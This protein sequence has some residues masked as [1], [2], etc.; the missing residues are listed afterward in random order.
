MK[1]KTASRRERSAYFDPAHPRHADTKRMRGQ[2]AE[3]LRTERSKTFALGRGMYQTVVYPERV[4]YRNRQG[5]W[6]EIDNRLRRV[7]RNGAADGG[8]A[9]ETTNGPLRMRLGERADANPL[10]TLQ[11]EQGYSIRWRLEGAGGAPVAQ[12]NVWTESADEDENRAHEDHSIATVRYAEALPHTDLICEMR[13]DGLKEALVLKNQSAPNRYAWTLDIGGLLWA[14]TGNGGLRLWDKEKPEVDAFLLPAPFMLDATGAEGILHTNWE[15]RDGGLVMTLTPDA[16]FL[17]NAQ[18][19]V[20]IDPTVQSGQVVAQIQDTFISETKGDTN[21][22]TSTTLRVGKH[23]GYGECKA[24]I[25]ILDLPALSS[26]YTI[27]KAWM[28]VAVLT[29]KT[30]TE[31]AYL[32]AREIKEAW[33][34]KT[35]KWNAGKPQWDEAKYL[36]YALVK[37]GEAAATT[38]Q[39]DLTNLVRKWYADKNTNWGVLLETDG[40]QPITL[41][42]AENTSYTSTA[43]PVIYVNY[44]SNAGLESY[45]SYESFGAGRAGTAHVALHSGNLVLTRGLTSMNGNRMPISL[46]MTWNAC[47]MDKNAFG[48]GNG[49]RLNWNQNLRREKPK[50]GDTYYVWTDEDGTEHEFHKH[51]KTEAEKQDTTFVDYYEDRSGLSLK[52]YEVGTEAEIVSKD[53][54][55]LVFDKPTVDYTATNNAIKMIK[56]ALD[57]L[58]NT[59]TFTYVASGTIFQLTQVADGAGRITT[60]A[61]SPTEVT[62]AP[63]GY[64][65][66]VKLT[67]NADKQLI[68]VTDLDSLTSAY[69]YVGGTDATVK[70][71]LKLVKNLV[72]GYHLEPTCDAT[73]RVTEM[74]AYAMDELNVR[75]DG[76]AR[77]Y[78]YFD[79][80]TQVKDLTVPDGKMLTYQFNDYGNVVAV[81][82]EL[83]FASFAKFGMGKPNT[84]EAVSKLQRLV[85]NLLDA[86]DFGVD[87]GWK[88]GVIGA[89]GVERQHEEIRAMGLKP[90]CMDRPGE[91]ETS[92]AEYQ[93]PCE[94][95]EYTFSVYVRSRGDVLA[96]AEAAWQDGEGQWHAVTSERVRRVGSALRLTCTLAL[97]EAAVVRCRVLAGEATGAA[98]FDRA[99]LETGTLCNRHN[100]LRNANFT[101]Q[102]ITELPTLELPESWLGAE[103]EGDPPKVQLPA[104]WLPS[105]TLPTGWLIGEDS[106]VLMESDIKPI[107][108]DNNEYDYP[109]S[110][111]LVAT[112][113]ADTRKA[114]VNTTYKQKFEKELQEQ[115]KTT[116]RKPKLR[117]V[118]AEASENKPRDL[119]ENCLQ[120]QG[121]PGVKVGIYQELDLHGDEGD[122][123]VVGGWCRA[124][125]A[126]GNENR[127]FRLRVRFQKVSGAWADGGTADWN[128]EWV[129]WQYACGAAVAPAAYRKVRVY[130]D[131]DE[132]LNEAQVG[133][134]SLVKEYYGQNFAYDDKNNVTAVSTLLGQ[135]SKAE[136]DKFD[137]L[138]S[139]VQ[140]GRDKSDK[141]T[142]YYGDTDVEKKKHLPLRSETSLGVITETRY[143]M[144]G[145]PVRSVTSNRADGKV[146]KA[147]TGYTQDGNYMIG[148]ID[149]L[150]LTTRSQV[151]PNR[152]LVLST[153]GTNGAIVNYQYDEANRLRKVKTVATGNLYC[154]EYSFDKDRIASISHNTTSDEPDVTYTFE[155]DALGNQTKVK[156]GT[157]TLSENCF[158]KTGDR[159]PELV[160]YTNGGK[161]H[162][163]YDG[164]K[165][166]SGIR[167]DDAI[168]PRFTYAYGANG[169][170]GRV[171]DTEL[172]REAR[173]AYDLAERPV[174]AELYE[175]GALKYR[176]TQEYDRYEQPSLLHERVEE[177]DDTR[178][179]YTITAQY[180]KES[181]PTV[182]TYEAKRMSAEGQPDQESTR[183]LTYSYDGLG[184]LMKRSFHGDVDSETPLFQSEYAYVTGGYGADSTTALVQAIEQAEGKHAYWYDALG[185]IVKERWQGTAAEGGALSF[186]EQAI[187]SVDDETLTLDSA[188]LGARYD[189]TYAYDPLGQLTRVNDQREQATW[190]Y[191]YDQGGNILEKKRYEYTT[192]ADLAALTPEQAIPYAYTD[193]NWKDKLTAYDDKP[194][195]Y[196][197]IGNP[198]TYD[199]WTYTWK[200]GR[201]LHSMEKGNVNAQFTYDHTGLRVKKS[202]SG[203]DTLYT[204]NGKKI[205]HI[206]KGQ[207]GATG[208]DAVQM[209]FFYDA[210]GRPT[211]VRYNG[212]DYAYLHN[213]QGDV[214]GIVDMSGALVVQYGYDAWGKPIGTGGSMAGTLG[215]DNPFRYRGYVW[216]EETGLYYLRSRYY[217]PVWGRFLN[218]DDILGRVAKMLSH[219]AY[220]Y[221]L[222]K[223]VS[224]VDSDGRESQQV[225]QQPNFKQLYIIDSYTVTKDDF[226]TYQDFLN[227]YRRDANNPSLQLPRLENPPTIEMVFG[228]KSITYTTEKVYIP[229]AGELVRDINQL[230]G[231]T[232]ETIAPAAAIAISWGAAYLGASLDPNAVA[233]VINIG[234]SIATTA[235]DKLM[236]AAEGHYH[237]RNTLTIERDSARKRKDQYSYDKC[238]TNAHPIKLLIGVI[239]GWLANFVK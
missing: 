143:D 208:T 206:R 8:Q 80:V 157:Q 144:F 140:P 201:M 138:T 67:L 82:D 146:M 186:E 184:R 232:G 69:E 100:L 11:D 19:P 160:E 133:A 5:E 134:V 49:W 170:V 198:L 132:G 113:N 168:E 78:T 77:G 111:E 176:L 235:I 39:F 17:Q 105:K 15:A 151:D 183:K 47:A 3:A 205:T 40:D 199:G 141:Y 173:M 182:L 28:G 16:E 24:L 21:Y 99:Q 152:G 123:Y 161:V 90:L 223:I 58:G 56:R 109:L 112:I 1:G 178:S 159:I 145:N 96:W 66:Q 172:G 180:D 68:T 162:Y 131:Y 38:A 76:N 149:S 185:N 54:S 194:I 46:G 165:R 25:R 60:L 71:R 236:P 124:W 212:I 26:A 86:H 4:H 89:D 202:V 23:E 188:A 22:A 195:T 192:A 215:R 224:F 104:G 118:A 130:I 204:L 79:C 95:G 196:D 36:D 73:G 61:Y 233:D 211:I 33:D 230:V 213:L 107:V 171:T 87:S 12:E 128:E 45:L 65:T 197:D 153:T 34:P 167:Y 238:E 229:T 81:H 175:D 154:N 50:T 62:I 203:M 136:Y 122:N 129:D 210:L 97:P 231:D 110:A 228:I 101:V 226:D 42:S 7:A 125:A 189:V 139:Y 83:G 63:P 59:A 53:H 222:N 174:E 150:G 155:T 148:K 2:E 75:M 92:Y 9:M 158:S 57:A 119:G 225:S 55:K 51:E 43:R 209:H 115:V 13:G 221:C 44:V 137:N 142:F 121:A 48:L 166:I 239:T 37:K 120:I 98:Y 52:L 32:Y 191:R 214:V 94:A 219:N 164:F 29:T 193:A 85:L 217:E 207:D 18:Y 126:P 93:K 147:Y 117:I 190:T 181:K 35:V 218:A 64:D 220:S 187:V 88:T 6:R 177:P 70:N 84:P 31:D 127:T 234:I 163:T 135:K 103:N 237:T 108:Y 27:A 74:H 227:N 106:G 114:E 30:N 156:V 102:D 41:T 169:A 10:V 216:D 116:I 72:D 200:A 14:E 179:E 91:D 20:T